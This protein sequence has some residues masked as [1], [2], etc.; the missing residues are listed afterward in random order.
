MT[1]LAFEIKRQRSM[2]GAVAGDREVGAGNLRTW[3]H[4]CQAKNGIV[5]LSGALICFGLNPDGGPLDLRW[6]QSQWRERSVYENLRTSDFIF[7]CDVFGDLLF[8][9][10]G[11]LYRL[12]GE[13][14]DVDRLHNDIRKIG[15]MS[16]QEAAEL[17]GGA[18]AKEAFAAS[19]LGMD[20]FRLMPVTPFLMA[21]GIPHSHRMVKLTTILGKKAEL[22]KR[23]QHLGDGETVDLS[24]WDQ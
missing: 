9:R 21:G 3:S 1:N 2:F 24:F 13:S 23:V 16:L 17:F 18:P 15:D 12:D 11:A 5:A 6:Y 4:I 22:A 20:P 14:G 7:G 10:G 19:V 8:E